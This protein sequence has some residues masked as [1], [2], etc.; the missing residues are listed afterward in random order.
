L[1]PPLQYRPCY[2]SKPLPSA[3]GSRMQPC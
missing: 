1:L 3:P 2:A